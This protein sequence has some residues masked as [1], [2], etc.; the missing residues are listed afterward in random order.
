MKYTKSIIL[1]SLFFILN[2]NTY[3]KNLVNV[4]EFPK[5]F[6]DAYAREVQVKSES[7]LEI[8]KLGIEHKVKGDFQ[9]IEKNNDSWYYNIDIGTGGPIE[10]YIFTEFDGPANSLHGIINNSLKGIESLN[11]KSLS[12]TF[13][14]CCR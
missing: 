12:S 1:I 4:D 9:L 7:V 8:K 3:A 2:V 11:K 5:W 6:K 10:C 14:F 13:N